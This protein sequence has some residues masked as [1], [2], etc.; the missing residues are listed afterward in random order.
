MERELFDLDILVGNWES[1]NLNP[2]VMIHRNGENHW[3]SIIYMNETSKQASPATYEIQ[4][5]DQGYFVYING[6]RSLLTYCQR[7]NML[8]IAMMGDYMRN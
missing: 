6:K 5:G 7:L 2:T 1:I 8:T 4:E 3:L